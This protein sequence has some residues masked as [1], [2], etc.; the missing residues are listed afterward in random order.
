MQALALQSLDILFARD[1]LDFYKAWPVIARFLPPRS[2]LRLV[3][4]EQGSHES[5]SDTLNGKYDSSSTATTSNSSSTGGRAN[6][7][8]LLQS[9]V[10]N[11]GLH[12]ARGLVAAHW[13]ALLRHGA[14]DAAAEP[15]VAVLVVHLMWMATAA[16]EAQVGT[17]G[18][19]GVQGRSISA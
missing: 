18:L 17:G 5:K 19:L 4:I 9:I 14:V 12:T 3:G 13:V 15:D 10:S 11:A 16:T 1:D 6:S 8:L 7:A 2:V